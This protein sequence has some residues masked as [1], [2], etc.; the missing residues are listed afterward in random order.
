MGCLEGGTDNAFV[1]HEPGEHP[2][3][4]GLAVSACMLAACSDPAPAVSGAPACAAGTFRA[5]GSQGG[6]C[7]VE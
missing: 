2:G 1:Q 3:V 6:V 7:A 5:P 4:L